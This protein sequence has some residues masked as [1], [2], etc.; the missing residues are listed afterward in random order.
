MQSAEIKKL[1]EQFDSKRR[2]AVSDSI[3]HTVEAMDALT[4]AT[5]LNA[6]GAVR[7]A[8]AVESLTEL[9]RASL[10]SNVCELEA[11]ESKEQ[12]PDLSAERVSIP[13]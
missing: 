12:V 8:E 10:E 7:T 9:L 1:I 4:R 13:K 6:L 5:L 2:G 3:R 11:S